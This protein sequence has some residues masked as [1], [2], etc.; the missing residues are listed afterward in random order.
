LE[1]AM[2]A[3]AIAVAGRVLDKGPFGTESSSLMEQNTSAKPS[4]SQSCPH[5][6]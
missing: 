1:T 5:S 2:L 6:S 4:P 3:A